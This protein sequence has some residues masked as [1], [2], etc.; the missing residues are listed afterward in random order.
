MIAVLN[1]HLHTARE[2][3]D[4]DWIRNIYAEF[5]SQ[6]ARLKTRTPREQLA[7][8]ITRLRMMRNDAI[9]HTTDNYP[10]LIE[11]LLNRLATSLPAIPVRERIAGLVELRHD[12]KREIET[13][14]QQTGSVP[15]QLIN[16]MRR[17][18]QDLLEHSATIETHLSNLSP[19][20]IG[21]LMLWHRYRTD[22]DKARIELAEGST[23]IQAAFTRLFDHL[24][25]KA[26]WLAEQG[27]AQ[28]TIEAWLIICDELV[29]YHDQWPSA[30][31][32]SPAGVHSIQT[33]PNTRLIRQLH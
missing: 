28:Q 17:A 19:K 5:D 25:E 18:A 27:T 24:R 12:L 26:E 11:H 6:L 15:E 30:A 14:I 3:G 4:A 1:N 7:L 33:W 9:P 8:D 29:A 22:A 32:P 31:Q 13:L 10:E 23:N 2:A 16:L 21:P 20:L